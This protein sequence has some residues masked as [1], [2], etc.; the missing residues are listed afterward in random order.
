[1][2]VSLVHAGGYAH[3]G[4]RPVLFYADTLTDPVL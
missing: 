2:A 3:G 4:E 1:M